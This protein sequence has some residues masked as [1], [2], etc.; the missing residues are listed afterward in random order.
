MCASLLVV[1][2]AEKRSIQIEDLPI[3]VQSVFPNLKNTIHDVEASTAGR[4]REGE[5]DH[6]IFYVL[7]STRFTKEPRIEPALSARSFQDRRQVPADA[8]RRML[9][10]LK[11]PVSVDERLAD[12]RARLQPTRDSLLSEYARSMSFLYQKEFK[13]SKNQVAD[14]YQTRGHSTDTQVEANY[15]V[16]NALEVLKAMRPDLVIRRVLVVGPGLDF[17]PRMDLFDQLP[18]QSYQP[19]ALADALFSLKLAQSSGFRL[20]CVDINPRVVDF[21][22]TFKG[23]PLPVLKLISKTA[24][25]EYQRYFLRLGSA[26]GT[27]QGDTIAVRKDVAESVSA[28]RLNILTERLTGE[29]FDLVVVTNVLLYFNPKELTLALANI[30]GMLKRGGYLIHNDLRPEI[31][32]DAV[33]FGLGPVQARTLR[34][35]R[36]STDPLFDSFAIYI[37]GDSKK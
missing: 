27:R 9:D 13:A 33:M 10:F 32:G 16:W 36:G 37:K 1:Q 6:L 22:N 2:P 30:A 4:L 23:R 7:Q 29:P 12:L 20:H 11:A 28:T 15:A 25:E 19:Y 5:N 31:D 18:P 21:V 14:L 24:D 3:A 26:I 17:A 35:A 8:L 34:V